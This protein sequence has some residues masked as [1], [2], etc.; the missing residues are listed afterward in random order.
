MANPSEEDKKTRYSDEELAEFQSMINQKIAESQKQ[1]A[2]LQSQITEL[3]E[4]D[5]T[6][7]SGAFEDG[8]S[9]WQREHL[10]KLASRAQKFIRD[11]EYALIRIKNQTYGICNVTGQLIDKKRLLLVPHATKSIEGKI[12]ENEDTKV[13]KKPLTSMDIEKR[14]TAQKK[15][16]SKIISPKKKNENPNRIDSDDEDDDFSLPEESLDLDG[17]VTDDSRE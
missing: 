5:E 7:R 8:A 6:S 2:D 1:L 13:V 3:N 4:N 14:N 12:N 15:I 17:L 10:G 9:N 16:I 11:L